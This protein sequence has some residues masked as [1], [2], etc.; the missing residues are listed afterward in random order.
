L[1]LSPGLKP[2]DVNGHTAQAFVPP[3]WI[4][5]LTARSGGG[6]KQVEHLAFGDA[7]DPQLQGDSGCPVGHV[8]QHDL[9]VPRSHTGV[10]VSS[11]PS[12]AGR[13]V[14]LHWGV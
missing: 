6:K 1:H 9:G 8:P 5:A 10:T 11:F 7:E 14:R 2:G 12:T 4:R 3:M 13:E